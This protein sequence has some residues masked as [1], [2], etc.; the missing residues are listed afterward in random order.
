MRPLFPSAAVREQ[1]YA[2]ISSLRAQ[3]S[4]I[5]SLDA[6]KPGPD[7][8][9]LIAEGETPPVPAR[10]LVVSPEGRYLHPARDGGPARCGAASDD[11][12]V[13]KASARWPA[14]NSQPPNDAHP[15]R[16]PHYT[17]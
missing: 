4:P 17:P 1:K 2:L 15:K 3:G 5:R 11:A 10:T 8:V 9:F 7:S 12:A 13:G 16:Q 6:D 14:H